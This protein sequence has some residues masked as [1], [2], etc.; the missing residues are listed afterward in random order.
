MIDY[1][2]DNNV[3]RITAFGSCLG[4][5][6]HYYTNWMLPKI[7]KKEKREEEKPK[8]QERT[9]IDRMYGSGTRKKRFF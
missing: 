6:F 8:K 7:D 1:R 2:D 5:E 3:D 9:M 4:L